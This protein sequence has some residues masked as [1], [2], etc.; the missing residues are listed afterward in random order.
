MLQHQ[1]PVALTDKEVD[2]LLATPTVYRPDSVDSLT[3]LEALVPR[4]QRQ[5]RWMDGINRLTLLTGLAIPVFLIVGFM[6][7][8][9]VLVGGVGG[10]LLL[11][12]WLRAS[13]SPGQSF[14]ETELNEA[15]FVPDLLSRL[16]ALIARQV[17]PEHDPTLVPLLLT[18][19]SCSGEP[20]VRTAASRSLARIRLKVIQLLPYLDND[21]AKALSPTQRGYLRREWLQPGSDPK[22]QVAALLTLASARDQE[23]AAL[24]RVLLTQ[25]TNEA[26]REAAQ[27]LL[28]SLEQ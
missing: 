5:R 12:L 28:K 26:V 16:L 13:A 10:S 24:V 7:G 3:L 20:G 6:T 21:R 8:P 17:E 14:D 1:R 27:E 23:S 11:F 2:Q 15:D 4:I 25:T 9:G 18:A 19:L 22:G